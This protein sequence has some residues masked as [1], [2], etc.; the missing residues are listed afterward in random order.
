MAKEWTPESGKSKKVLAAILGLAGAASFCGL[1]YASLNCESCSQKF[2]Q[3]LSSSKGAAVSLVEK[4]KAE[5]CKEIKGINERLECLVSKY[6]KN[7]WKPEEQKKFEEEFDVSLYGSEDELQSF[8]RVLGVF[9]PSYHI[10][11]YLLPRWAMAASN[12]DV[13]FGYLLEKDKICIVKDDG[14]LDNYSMD[15]SIRHEIAHSYHHGL[16]K[17]NEFEAK[18]KALNVRD[19]EDSISGVTFVLLTG[20]KKIFQTPSGFITPYAAKN[21][22][23]DIAEHVEEVHRISYG[24]FPPEFTKNSL[25]ELKNESHIFSIDASDSGI[26][27]GKF[28]LLREYG[29]ISDY[30][31]SEAMKWLELSPKLDSLSEKEIYILEE[32][33]Y[34]KGLWLM[35]QGLADKTVEERVK[36]YDSE[37]WAGT[38]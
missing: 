25:E 29:F 30:E 12:K 17:A 35:Q 10:D 9:A 33:N 19:Y 34:G 31:Y 8:K 2:A 32:E 20:E 22:R 14:K 16:D 6:G 37:A 23:E 1:V 13:Y 18:W 26:H 11:F 24:I 36:E 38:Y 28:R 7:I 21:I 4:N 27:S 15:Q 3:A 5:E